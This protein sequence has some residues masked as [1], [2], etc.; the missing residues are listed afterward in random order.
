MDELKYRA[1]QTD[2]DSDTITL[3]DTFSTI[4]LYGGNS[5]KS[6]LPTVRYSTIIHKFL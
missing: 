2:I 4:Y 1:I 3:F 6:N 5:I